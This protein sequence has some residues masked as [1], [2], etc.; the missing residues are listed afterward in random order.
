MQRRVCNQLDIAQFAIRVRLAIR[1][2]RGGAGYC[3]AGSVVPGGLPGSGVCHVINHRGLPCA[4]VTGHDVAGTAKHR[5]PQ[6][7]RPR[8]ELTM[9]WWRIPLLLAFVVVGG[10]WSPAQVKQVRARWELRLILRKQYRPGCFVNRR[11]NRT[12]ARARMLNFGQHRNAHRA[13]L[14]GAMGGG[15]ARRPDCGPG[16]RQEHTPGG[17]CRVESRPPHRPQRTGPAGCCPGRACA[18]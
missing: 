6:G 9:P 2:R 16:R 4:G 1:V 10:A 7:I 17:R 14:P 11:R 18:G 8:A 15:G 3:H 13:G 5:C 12:A